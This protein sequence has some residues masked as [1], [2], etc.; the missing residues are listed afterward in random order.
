MFQITVFFQVAVLFFQ[1]KKYQNLTFKGY[2]NVHIKTECTRKI[3]TGSYTQGQRNQLKH[4]D[5]FTC[6]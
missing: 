2:S 3:S 4:N 1:I 5:N 6:R